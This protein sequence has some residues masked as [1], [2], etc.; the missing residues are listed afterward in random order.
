MNKKSVKSVAE[1]LGEM[2][3]MMENNDEPGLGSPWYN[4]AVNALN[5]IYTN[6]DWGFVMKDRHFTAGSEYIADDNFDDDAMLKVSGD[7]PEG[8]KAKYA[9]MIANA[10]NKVAEM[11]KSGK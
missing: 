11:E 6:T 4:D 2:V 5:A 9:Q 8:G 1:V 10:L 7:F 3:I